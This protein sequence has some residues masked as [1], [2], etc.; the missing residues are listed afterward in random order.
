M[1]KS[2]AAQIR[3]TAKKTQKQL[4]QA[5]RATLLDI[6]SQVVIGTP[7]LHG[8]ARGNWL[9]S[10]GTPKTQTDLKIR[11]NTGEQAQ[12]AIDAEIAILGGNNTVFYFVNSL[13]YI[14]RLE[15][16]HSESRP[17]GML[18]IAVNQFDKIYKEKVKYFVH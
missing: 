8:I 16:G 6:T 15:Y 11:D 10:Y 7:V 9:A 5:M 14:R 4:D 17:N 18:R 2:V 13:P 12:G 1:S 3:A